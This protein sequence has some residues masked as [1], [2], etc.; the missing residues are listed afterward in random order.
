MSFKEE[1][2]LSIFELDKNAIDQPSLF[3]EQSNNWVEAVLVRDK[4]KEALSVTMATTTLAI[5]ENP[6]K[7]GWD[8]DKAPTEAWFNA[9]VTL[10]EEVRK[11]TDELLTAQHEVNL[12]AKA[13]E[14]LEQRGRS[15]SILTEQYKGNYWSGVSKTNWDRVEALTK[16]SE[17]EQ[18]KTLK[19]NP[20]LVKRSEKK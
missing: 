10:S 11:A 9:K 17:E 19:E 13:T 4:A 18:H 14:T 7:F 8:G 12:F 3:D 20:R 16:K 5:R 1:V 6:K 2:K 15:L